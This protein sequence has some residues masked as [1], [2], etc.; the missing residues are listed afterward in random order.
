[1]AKLILKFKN[2]GVVSVDEAKDFLALGRFCSPEDASALPMILRKHH[3]LPEL[4]K[5]THCR[6][7]TRSFS[8]ALKG[9]LIG[10]ASSMDK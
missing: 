3:L 8:P 1:M 7:L 5:T 4:Y 9:P 2:F 6:P 10:Y